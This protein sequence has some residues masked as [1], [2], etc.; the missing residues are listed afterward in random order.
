MTDAGYR[1]PSSAER[2]A[3]STCLGPLHAIYFPWLRAEAV[4][5]ESGD[6]RSPMLNNVEN[7]DFNELVRR[8]FGVPDL[9][10]D[11]VGREAILRTA[12]LSSSTEEVK[13]V[14]DALSN[15]NVRQKIDRLLVAD[16]DESLELT[17]QSV[18][19]E[20]FAST[21]G[22]ATVARTKLSR[23]ILERVVGFVRTNP[24]SDAD[25]RQLH[26][27]VPEPLGGS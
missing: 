15:G 26:F 25:G 21:S 3:P 2:L 27:E 13:K 19:A 1:D 7:V 10:G 4:L 24:F 20:A 16:P 17:A 5:R 11:E 18:A 22:G 23:S 9:V 8:A 14:I 6:W 12:D